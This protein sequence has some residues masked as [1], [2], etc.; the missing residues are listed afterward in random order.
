MVL[1]VSVS[2]QNKLPEQLPPHLYQVDLSCSVPPGK[3]LM[4]ASRSDPVSFQITISMLILR[5]CEILCKPFKSGVTVSNSPLVPL[6]TQVHGPSKAWWS[7]VC[8]R[9]KTPG[10]KTNNR[11]LTLHSLGKNCLIVMTLLV[12]VIYLRVC[13]FYTA[14]LPFYPSCGSFLRSL[15]MEKLFCQSSG[16]SERWLLC[17]QL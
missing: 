1:A 17:K 7:E 14:S 2:W 3:L 9:S 5:A 13:F 10:Q 15:I 6:I 4:S 11:L 12:Q 16:H 8:L